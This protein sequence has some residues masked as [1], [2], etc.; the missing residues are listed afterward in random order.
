[1]QPEATGAAAE[2]SAAE[3]ETIELGRQWFLVFVGIVL[4]DQLAVAAAPIYYR[5]WIAAGWGAMQ[6]LCI[7][8][9]AWLV[10]A[11]KAP[12]AEMFATV[13]A[14][15]GT[16]RLAMVALLVLQPMFMAGGKWSEV[17]LLEGGTAFAAVSAAWYFATAGMLVF[18]P[19]V[20][21]YLASVL[22]AN[23]LDKR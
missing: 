16:T 7:A 3:A 23:R 2:R 11:G 15:F 22:K 4:I 17:R 6:F 20:K 19:A 10:Y 1:M 21:Q 13:L 18:H 8:A 14:I 12:L 5:Q 9:G